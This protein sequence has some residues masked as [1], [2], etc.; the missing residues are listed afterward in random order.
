MARSEFGDEEII[1]GEIIDE[2]ISLADELPDDVGLNPAS[3]YEDDPLVGAPIIGEA[4]HVGNDKP[5]FR[6]LRGEHIDHVRLP[7][8][9]DHDQDLGR[10][11]Y[12]HDYAL[13]PEDVSIRDL[14][15]H[16]P[17]NYVFA[18]FG[19]PAEAKA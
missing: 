10:L 19:T 18:L 16:A 9:I 7:G 4:A 8:D 14:A 1:D 5:D 17:A 15:D 3:D 6:I 12:F 2:E 13:I 11:D